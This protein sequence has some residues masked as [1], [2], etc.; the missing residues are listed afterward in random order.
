MKNAMTGYVAIVAI[1]LTVVPGLN[2]AHAAESSA[3]PNISCVDR[4]KLPEYPRLAQQAMIS[5]TVNAHVVLSST[6]Q[7]ERVE[8]RAS[9][10]A[11]NVKSVLTTPVEAALRQ[12]VFKSG[13]GGKSV[14]FV[15]I[16]ELNGNTRGKPKQAVS[17]GFPNKFWIVSEAPMFQ[18]QSANSNPGSEP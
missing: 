9:T 8:T 16:F 11:P 7:P 5:G 18:P 13:C 1:A 10:V 14:E 2:C 3:P 4:I 17:Y 12:A 6:A 15:F